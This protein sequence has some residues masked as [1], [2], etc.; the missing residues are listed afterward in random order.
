MK[1]RKQR[2]YKQNR[3][4]TEH[5]LKSSIPYM[6][7]LL[8]SEDRMIKSLLSNDESACPSESNLNGPITDDNLNYN[9]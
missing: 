8:N 5:Y 9:K 3:V 4:Y 1:Q 2:K 7:S 6:Q